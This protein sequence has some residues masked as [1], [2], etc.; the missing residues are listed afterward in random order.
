MDGQEARLTEIAAAQHDLRE[1]ER[2]V[3]KTDEARK[4]SKQHLDWE[5][6]K[7]WRKQAKQRLADLLEEVRHDYY[8]APLSLPMEGSASLSSEGARA[9]LRIAK[10]I[11][12]EANRVGMG[13]GMRAGGEAAK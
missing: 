11:Q 13:V 5:D 1:A 6:A 3:T 2:A 7:E 9:A 4:Y 12:D 8:Q 10:G